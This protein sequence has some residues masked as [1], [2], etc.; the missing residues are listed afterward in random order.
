MPVRPVVRLGQLGRLRVGD[1]KGATKSIRDRRVI[2]NPPL[3]SRRILLPLL[4]LF[5][6]DEPQGLWLTLPVAVTL[7]RFLTPLWVFILTLGIGT[8]ARL[9]G[10]SGAL[11]CRLK[12][13]LRT[14]PGSRRSS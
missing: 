9:F 14:G 11:E 10:R 1:Q 8:V 5:R 13:V 12:I 6:C 3:R 2:Q 4:W 7:N